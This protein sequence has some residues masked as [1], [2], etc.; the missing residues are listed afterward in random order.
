MSIDWDALVLSPVMAIFGEGDGTDASLPTY[1]PAAGGSFALAD[2]VFDREYLAVT[3]NDDGSENATRKP[4]LGVRLARFAEAGVGGPVQND[5]VLI[6]SVGIT[7]IVRE[8]QPDGHGHALLLL[9]AT[10][11]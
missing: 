6:P 4:I 10:A 2:A 7:Y 11:L 1:M 3:T 5:K 8:V 9:N